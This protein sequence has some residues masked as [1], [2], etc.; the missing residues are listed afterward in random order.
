MTFMKTRTTELLEQVN[1]SHRPVVISRNGEARAV[2]LDV[3]SYESL[4]DAT[5]ILQLAAHSEAAI[6]AGAT[7]PQ[8]EVFSRVRSRLNRK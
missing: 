8:R 6:Q 3:E 4:R 5:S 7:L 2:V 1:A